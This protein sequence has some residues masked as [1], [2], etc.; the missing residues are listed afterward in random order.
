MDVGARFRKLIKRNNWALAGS[1]VIVAVSGGPDSVAL[2][3]LFHRYLHDV[4]CT[5][6]VAHV[7]HKLRGEESDEEEHFVRNIASQLG[8]IFVSREIDMKAWKEG[9]RGNMHEAARHARYHFLSELASREKAEY[10]ATGHHLDDMAETLLMR[11]LRGTGLEGMRGIEA[12]R[13]LGNATLIRP[14]LRIPKQALIAFCESEQLLWRVDSS[15]QSDLYTRNA[16]RLRVLPEIDKLFGGYRE[17]LARFSEIAGAEDDYLAMEAN[18]AFAAIITTDQC[19]YSM[20][21]ENFMMLHLALQ[22][23]LIKLLLNCLCIE[24]H[25]YIMRFDV[26]SAIEAIRIAITDTQRPNVVSYLSGNICMAREYDQIRFGSADFFASRHDASQR[27]SHLQGIIDMEEC[28]I[29][30]DCLSANVNELPFDEVWFDADKLATP[31]HVRTRN[32]GDRLEPFG[33]SGSRKVKNILIDL[34]VPMHKR[35]RI[36]LIFDGEGR[37]LW[38]A[39]VRRSRY[40]LVDDQTKRLLK[41][42]WRLDKRIDEESGHD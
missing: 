7:N 31:L 18:R 15:N 21:R 34:K 26:F 24:N 29:T 39:G 38:I 20:S 1:K 12:A 6:I 11:L 27:F 22:R 16:L 32:E 17:S 19:I 42:I 35:D 2:L 4:D 33:M 10:V 41:V 5:L 14:L 36:P 40:A 28:S 8:C 23:R 9:G 25:V 37:L 30:A 3:Y 13:P